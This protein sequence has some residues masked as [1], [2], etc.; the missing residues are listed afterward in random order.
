MTRSKIGW[1]LFIGCVGSG[2][3]SLG[4]WLETMDAEARAVVDRACGDDHHPRVR[5]YFNSSSHAS[6]PRSILSVDPAQLTSSELNRE[7]PPSTCPRFAGRLL[8]CH[9]VS[10]AAGEARN[11]A[12]SF[13]IQHRRPASRIEARPVPSSDHVPGFQLSA[14]RIRVLVSCFCFPNSGFSFLHGPHLSSPLDFH[15]KAVAVARY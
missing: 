14:S 12:A 9:L 10:G 15:Q 8:F 3:A 4:Y 13:P 5:D 2:L 6:V 1:L 11:L 7:F